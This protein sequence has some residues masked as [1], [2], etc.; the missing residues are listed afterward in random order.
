M[1]LTKEQVQPL[2]R[3]YYQLICDRFGGAKACPSC[4]LGDSKMIPKCIHCKNIRTY[5]G[6]RAIRDIYL[7]D[8]GFNF[9]ELPESEWPVTKYIEEH[10]RR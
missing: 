8:K 2:A 6:E 7:M 9:L 4:G 5:S 10:P 1:K 3:R